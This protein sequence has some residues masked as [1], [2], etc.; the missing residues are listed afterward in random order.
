[1]TIIGVVGLTL[2][3]LSIVTYF[4]PRAMSVTLW[5]FVATTFLSAALLLVLPG[6]FANVAM[7]LALAMPLLW[8][9]LQFWAMWEARTWRVLTSFGAISLASAVVIVFMDPKI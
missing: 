5:A 1:M 6:T 4:A 9:G 8:V 7:W 2:I 3:V